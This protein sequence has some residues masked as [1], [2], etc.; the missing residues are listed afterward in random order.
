MN[1]HNRIIY[2]ITMISILE[3]SQYAII[4][5]D[6]E[7]SLRYHDD[8]L[9]NYWENKQ[10]SIAV[11][12]IKFSSIDEMK[13][14]IEEGQF[15]IDEL[16]GMQLFAKNSRGETKIC[17]LNSLFDVTLP[18]GVP[19]ES[20]TWFGQE[21][22][23]GF[24]GRF[25]GE[26]GICSQKWYNSEID[27]RKYEKNEKLTIVSK[28]VIEDRNATVYICRNTNGVSFKDIQYTYTDKDKVIHFNELY[29]FSDYASD[30]PTRIDFCGCVNGQYFAGSIRGFSSRPTYE[31]LQSFG[32]T[33]YV[34]TETE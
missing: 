34:E 33:P 17:N 13:K 21:Y 7:Y 18:D 12:T 9:K 6:G 23:F 10:G 25:T 11:P 27:V 24:G 3:N 19:L 20:V 8:E 30:I 26:L 15:T 22:S 2:L 1:L 16:I 32:L 14:S 28:N 29:M 4:E 31:W 5:D